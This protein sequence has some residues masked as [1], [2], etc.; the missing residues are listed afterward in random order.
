M[1]FGLER[2]VTFG[3]VHATIRNG[4][5]RHR[6]ETM[7]PSIR[8]LLLANAATLALALIFDWS[9]SWLLWPYWIQSVIIGWYARKRMLNLDRFTTR[10]FTSGGGPV[11]ETDAG[12][13]STANFFAFHYGFF[14]VGYLIFLLSS[15]AVFGLW[16]MLALLGCGLSFVFSQRATYAA[17][18][19]ADLRGRPNLG[20]L[21]ATPYLRI[22]PMHLAVLFGAQASDGAGMLIVF[23]AL[24]TLSDIGLDMVDRRMAESSLRRAKA[25]EAVD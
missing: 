20:H 7:A 18:R 9:P 22:V 13:R 2:S 23:T 19:A 12:K 25:P 10:G 8:N 1:T 3:R 15:H 16:D 6:G 17:Q 4:A 11:P 21:M 24:K 5:F 14:H